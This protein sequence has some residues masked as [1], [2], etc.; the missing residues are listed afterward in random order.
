MDTVGNK[1]A[2][3]EI[4]LIKL[5]APRMAQQVVDRAIQAGQLHFSIPL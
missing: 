1:Q 2:R 5:V 4:A 3:K